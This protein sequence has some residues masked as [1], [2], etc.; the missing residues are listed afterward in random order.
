MIEELKTH[1]EIGCGNNRRDI[2]HMINI[3][4]DLFDGPCVDYVVNLGF[5]VLPFE[6]SSVDIVQAYD[7]LEHIPKCVWGQVRSNDVKD[8]DL[9]HGEV[10]RHERYTP[11]I[12]LMNEVFRILKHNGKFI[13]EVPFGDEAWNRDP[14]HVSRFSSDWYHYY[15]QHDNLYAEQ[16]LVTCNFKI[17]PQGVE[18]RRY[19]WTDKDI[20][21]TEL[22]A[23]KEIDD[24]FSEYEP[25]I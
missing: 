12:F 11:L 3:G 25:F 17:E 4:V 9:W 14:T 22:V 13:I 7:V 21:R 20:M 19:Q 15:E 24:I 10:V 18:F 5:E 8:A 2:D 6:D 16:G 1:V 23:I